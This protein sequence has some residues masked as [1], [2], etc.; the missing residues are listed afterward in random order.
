MPSADDGATLN[1]VAVR[2]AKIIVRKNRI[3]TTL[4]GRTRSRNG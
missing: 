2:A 1:N 4:F 3:I